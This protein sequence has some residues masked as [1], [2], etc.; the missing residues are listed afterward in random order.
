MFITLFII[1]SIAFMVVR[2]MPGSM[3]DNP[4]LPIEVIQALEEKSHLNKPMIVQ[5]GYFFK[6]CFIRKQLGEYLL[7]LNQECLHSKL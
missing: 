1:L 4:E 6:G 2:L 3:Y 5:Y 7:K